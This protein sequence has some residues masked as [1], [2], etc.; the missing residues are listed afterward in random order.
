MVTH[1]FIKQYPIK[2]GQFL[3]QAEAVGDGLEAK[4]RILDGAVNVNDLEE[5]RRGRKLYFGDKVSID[6]A[7]YICDQK[8]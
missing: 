8:K 5:I 3:K 7:T 4:L 1:I 6:G 2:L